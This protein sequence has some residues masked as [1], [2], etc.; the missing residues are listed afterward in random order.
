M[1]AHVL[2]LSRRQLVFR[3]LE[4]VAIVATSCNEIRGYNFPCRLWL[5]RRKYDGR[6]ERTLLVTD[7]KELV[8]VGLCAVSHNEHRS[9]QNDLKLPTVQ[10]G[11][12]AQLAADEVKTEEIWPKRELTVD[13]CK[14]KKKKKFSQRGQGT[15]ASFY[16][17]KKGGSFDKPKSNN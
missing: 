8:R 3:F 4:T 14:K 16:M 2:L 7:I 5:S 1:S 9:F 13:I 15:V 17:V 10:G 6:T 12:E 11:P